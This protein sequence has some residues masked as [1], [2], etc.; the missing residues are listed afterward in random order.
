MHYEN[1]MFFHLGTVIPC[2]FIGAFLLLRPKGGM[3]HRSLGKI[4]MSLMM[5]TATTTLFMAN[6]VGPTFLG[7]FGYIHLFSFL[8]IWSVPT[9]L[10]AIRQGN[11]KRHQ[12]IMWSLYIGAILIAGGFTFVPGR[13]MYGL[14]FG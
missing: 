4:Y 9:A 12:R 7:H 6:K 5:I 3:V 14:I 2:F 1:L 13:Y 10:F 8:T 11:V